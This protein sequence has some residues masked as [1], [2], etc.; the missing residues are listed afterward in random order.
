MKILLTTILALAFP[1]VLTKDSENFGISAFR[2]S[3][4][5]TIPSNSG[6]SKFMRIAFGSCYG[7]WDFESNI[8]ETIADDQ[9]DLWIW[10]G[11]VA[12]VD[13]HD[14]VSLMKMPF[15]ENDG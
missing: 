6:D 14:I 5:I 11:D 2:K 7:I 4:E 9:P 15:T 8:F 1:V 13:A 12:Y 3:V 10:L